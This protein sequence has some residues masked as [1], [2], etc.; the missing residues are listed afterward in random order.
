MYAIYNGLHKVIRAVLFVVLTA[1]VVVV[2][3]QIVCRYVFFYSL[4]WSEEL[5]RYMFAYLI[6]IGAGFGIADRSS[7]CI[8]I[9]ETVTS[10]NTKKIIHFVQ[11]L[12]SL[13]AVVFLLFSSIEL[14]KLGGKQLSPAMNVPMSV[15]YLCMP[16]GFILMIFEIIVKIILFFKGKDIENGGE[17]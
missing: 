3:A 10:G 17:K 14:M 6:L 11:Y 2:T 5:S 4:S 15:V 13:A 7:I 8:D 9:V 1:M 16:I 12:V